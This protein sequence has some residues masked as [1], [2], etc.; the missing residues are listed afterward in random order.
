MKRRRVL[1][2]FFAVLVAVSGAVAFKSAK[3]GRSSTTPTVPFSTVSAAKLAVGGISLSPPQ[4]NVSPSAADGQAAAAAASTFY[5]GRNVLEYHFVHCVDAQKA[6]VLSQDCWAVSLDPTGLG[7]SGPEGPSTNQQ[8]STTQQ[9]SY[10]LVLIDPATDSFI[11]A[12]S[13]A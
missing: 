9:A 10:L 5:G 1:L 12:Q 13:G 7:F 3:T 6:P 11:E 2:V 8:A 4:S